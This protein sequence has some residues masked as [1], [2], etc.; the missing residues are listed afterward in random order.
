MCLCS[1]AVSSFLRLGWLAWY[2]SSCCLLSTSAFCNLTSSDIHKISLVVLQCSE[3]LYFQIW[4]LNPSRKS[5][6]VWMQIYSLGSRLMFTMI[7]FFCRINFWKCFAQWMNFMSQ[8]RF[9]FTLNLKAFA[10][11]FEFSMQFYH[12]YI[13]QVFPGLKILDL[14]FHKL[15]IKFIKSW[16]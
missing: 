9:H 6:N 7:R 10:W 5:T 16:L 12:I 13:H 15:W 3:M 8:L 1:P 2:L 4:H 11:M 14:Q